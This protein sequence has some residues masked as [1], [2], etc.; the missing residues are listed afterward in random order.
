MSFGFAAA[1]YSEK[2]GKVL[3]FLRTADPPLVPDD[4]ITDCCGS[5][6]PV[7]PTV[8]TGF[9]SRIA[10]VPSF[11]ATFGARGDV[12]PPGRITDLVIVDNDQE[13]DFLYT[14]AK[15]NEIHVWIGIQE[16]VTGTN[17]NNE[18]TYDFF[19]IDG[20]L[21]NSEAETSFSKWAEG[22]NQPEY[23]KI[24]FSHR[25]YFI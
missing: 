10:T 23:G 25:K 21:V 17:E 4:R 22:G 18:T 2:C 13:N 6:I 24:F 15:E 19:W 12:A 7:G 16:K 20:Q 8:P 9:F 5:F 3:I 1:G 11:F 14:F